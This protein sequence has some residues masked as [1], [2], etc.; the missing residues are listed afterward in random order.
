MAVSRYADEK[1]I[2]LAWGRIF[3]AFGPHEHPARLASSVVRALLS[4][5]EALCSDGEQVRD[6][7]YA[8]QLAEAF[9][10]LLRSEVTGPVN[11]A[12]GEARPVRDLI[13]ALAEAVGRPDLV[14]LG[15]RPSPPR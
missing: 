7:L 2:S 15:A 4:G 13:F 5:S 12:S 10:A 11:M 8:P 9:V 1:R 14:R 3:F 6:F